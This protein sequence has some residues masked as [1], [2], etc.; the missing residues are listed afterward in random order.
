M[1]RVFLFL[2]A[3]L[4]SADLHAQSDSVISFVD[5]SRLRISLLTCGTGE[6][7]WETFGHTAIRVVDSA[8]GTDIVYNYGTFDGFT[9]D[10]ELKFMQGKLLYYLSYY[11]YGIFIR[12]YRDA[13]R[14]VEE[15]VLLL[16]GTRK[17]NIY[18][19]LRWNAS[20]G[21]KYYKYDFFYDNCATRV[22][23]VFP[24]TFGKYFRF[25]QA[26]PPDS[27]LSFREIMNVYFYRNHF[28]RFGINILLGS[29]IDKI[30]TNEEIM[31]LPEYLKTGIGNA[32]VRGQKLASE[33]ELILSGEPR[34]PAG[35][36][37]ALVFTSLLALLTVSGIIIKPLR[38]LGI[39]MSNFM[40][41]LTGLI[42][43][44]ILV[45]WFGTDHQACR[46][47]FNLLWALPTNVVIV[48]ASKK[49]K[50]KYSAIAMILIFAALLVHVLK[51]QELPL[52]E[53]S[54]ILVSLLVIYGMIYRKNK[55]KAHS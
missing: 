45:M 53:L 21:N 7:I 26:I 17:E 32:T 3:F 35:I 40:L 9:E 24:K 5:T 42:G 38:P 14:S 12:E 55:I 28:E 13:G 47:N 25:G 16:D 39:F 46:D 31:F 19:F 52:L 6:E 2:L 54:P 22:R 11:P 33:P 8:E 27:K 18:Q 4:F 20:E 37:W 41:L 23:D 30:M 15:Q 49:N 43:L 10:F 29:E 1:N 34:P 51:V 50:D 44:L 48:M 36:N